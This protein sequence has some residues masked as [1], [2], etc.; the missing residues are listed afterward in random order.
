VLECGSAIK[1]NTIGTLAGRLPSRMTQSVSIYCTGFIR[2][3]AVL[4]CENPWMGYFLRSA[5]KFLA[6]L[7]IFPTGAVSL[8][9]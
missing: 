5:Q 8:S 6:Q 1:T 4:T 3:W 2:F 7:A 9:A